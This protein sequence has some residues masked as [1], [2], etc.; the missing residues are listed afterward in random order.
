MLASGGWDR[1]VHF[2]DIRLKTS[3]KK[4]FGS[5]IGAEAIDFRGF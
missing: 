5:Y 2:W 3:T 1:A 4:I